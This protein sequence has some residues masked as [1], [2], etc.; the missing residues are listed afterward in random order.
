MFLNVRLSNAPS[1][2]GQFEFKTEEEESIIVIIF[3]KR[4]VTLGSLS[5]ALGHQRGPVG[6]LVR[7]EPK[8]TTTS[9]LPGA[10]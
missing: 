2:F 6:P 9:W 4:L 10:H 1:Y 3:A 8:V 7:T 5:F